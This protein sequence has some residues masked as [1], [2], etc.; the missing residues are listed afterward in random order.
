MKRFSTGLL[1]GLLTGL[2]LATTTFALADNPIKLIV[3][4]KEI[5]SEV[6]P[7]VINGRTMVPARFL[8]EALGATVAW[9]EAQNAVVVTG[10]VQVGAKPGDL[11]P[12]NPTPANPSGFSDYISGK[13]L[14]DTYSAEISIPDTNSSLFINI[15]G[16]T[17]EISKE[18]QSK[19]NVLVDVKKDGKVV[20]QV[21]INLTNGLFISKKL[22]SFW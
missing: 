18:Q 9:D 4:G 12:I 2:I 10:G 8:A 15:K 11:G 14:K 1:I 6:P 21:E 20:G 16:L 22:L 17:V 3:N 13:E 7:Q 5:Q 19:K